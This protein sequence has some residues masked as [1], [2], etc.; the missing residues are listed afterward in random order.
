MT[1]P[2][3]EL[4]GREVEQTEQVLVSNY[5]LIVADRFSNDEKNHEKNISGLT[6][7]HSLLHLKPRIVLHWPVCSQH[8]ALELPT[9]LT[10]TAPDNIE[11]AGLAI[12]VFYDTMLHIT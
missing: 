10:I 8:A 1:Q 4:D 11:P 7:Q 12:I 9:R 2:I 6:F 5:R 3:D